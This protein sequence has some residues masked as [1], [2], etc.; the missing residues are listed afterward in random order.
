M[1]EDGKLHPLQDAFADL[2]AA[3]CAIA[4]RQFWL[5]RRRCSIKI[6]TLLAINSG[7]DLWKLVPLHWLSSIFEAVEAAMLK[8]AD[9]KSSQRNWLGGSTED[10]SEEDACRFEKDSRKAPI[11]APKNIGD[12]LRVIW[13]PSAQS[14]C[15]REGNRTNAL[16]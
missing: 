6:L 13:C 7:I 9:Q 14:R 10:Y 16:R 1:G 15:P 12:D 11:D 3:Q 4:R 5:L 2:G 8:I